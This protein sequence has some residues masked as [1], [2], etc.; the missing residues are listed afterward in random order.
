VLAY[1]S[2][3]THRVAISNS[4]LIA[5]D[6]KGVT[7]KWKDCR[8]KGRDRLKTT[9]LGDAE[10]IRRCLLH[11]LPSGFDSIATTASDALQPSTACASSSPPLIRATNLSAVATIRTA[12]PPIAITSLQNQPRSVPAAADACASSRHSLVA[13]SPK[14]SRPNRL[15]STRHDR[16]PDPHAHQPSFRDDWFRRSNSGRAEADR[17]GQTRPAS[18]GQSA[19]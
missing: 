9:T 19:I 13:L 16:R 5:L 11:V 2:G 8:I 14:A 12:T 10:F 18:R 6:D 17:C 4:R 15:E 7:F 1:L 3:Y